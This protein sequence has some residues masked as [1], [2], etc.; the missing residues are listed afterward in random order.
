MFCL[1][2][3]KHS[4]KEFQGLY[5]RVKKR[6]N[7]KTNINVDSIK[8]FLYCLSSRWILPYLDT[9]VLFIYFI[10]QVFACLGFLSPANR[11][12]LMTCAMVLFVC[13]GTPAGYVSARVYKSFGGEKWKSNVLLTSML[14]PGIVF[15][16]FFVMN[17]VLW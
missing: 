16:H 1:I 4:S 6:G 3:V 13:L 8:G 10:F 5:W 15:A 9:T 2:T 17:L 14:C 12:S 7:F 11:G